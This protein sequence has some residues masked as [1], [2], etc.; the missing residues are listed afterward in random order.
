[1]NKRHILIV[2]SVILLAFAVSA[3]AQ[4]YSYDY[5]NM[6]MDEYQAELTKWQKRLADAQAALAEQE[7]RCAQLQEQIAA[8]DKEIEDNW[9]EIYSMLGTDKTGYDDFTN[10]CKALE[11]DV[12]A[13]LAL[14]PEDMYSRR[15]ELDGY[16][17]RLAE[18]R[19][20]KRSLGPEPYR[21]LQNVENLINQA[22]EKAQPAAAGKYEVARGDY[23]WKIAKKP[24]IYG[25]PYTWI[26]IYTYNRDQIKNPDLIYPQQVFSIPRMAGPGEYWVLKGESLG[27]ISKKMGSSFTWHKLYEANKDVIGEDA[28]RIYP[29]MVL[30]LPN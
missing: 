19:K 13:F 17:A 23:L 29:H 12:S 5:K 1:M 22:K 24:E 21:V 28:A 18:L 3:F 15:A 26:R 20:D 25:D 7:A 11:N 16:E 4:Q 14:S 10:Q 27:A 9:G 8:A 6:K 2:A 30:R